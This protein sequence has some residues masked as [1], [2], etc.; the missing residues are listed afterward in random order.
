MVRGELK[1]RSNRLRRTP[2]LA[3]IGAMHELITEAGN[4]AQAIRHLPTWAS[5]EISAQG[6][7]R[8][9]LPPELAGEDTTARQQI[10]IVEAVSAI[11]GSVGWCVH[12]NSEINSLVIRQMQP[13]VAQEIYDDWDVVMCAGVGPGLQDAR[14]RRDGDGW[15][16]GRA[17]V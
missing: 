10:E 4:E 9:A 12:I 2:I 5:K 13:D 17:H 7:Y 11:D 8:F 6:L 1:E 15:Q 14:A 16:I 3:R